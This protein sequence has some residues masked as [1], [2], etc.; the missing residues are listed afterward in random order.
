[1]VSIIDI[2]DRISVSEVPGYDANDPFK[3]K[4]CNNDIIETECYS[5]GSGL[6]MCMRCYSDEERRIE[7]AHPCIP[8]VVAMCCITKDFP[9]YDRSCEFRPTPDEYK[10]GDR[11]AY[12]PNAYVCGCR[13]N[14]TNY[15]ELIRAL[16][17]FDAADEVVYNA[18]RER[19][20]ELVLGGIRRANPQEIASYIIDST[21]SI[22]YLLR[23]DPS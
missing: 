4:V 20:D 18:I 19:I 22:E 1:M 6:V 3:C 5:E 13:H 16:V 15:N 11:E 8:D 9:E 17:K 7:E 23:V 2:V 21:Y 10:I 12:T 14:C